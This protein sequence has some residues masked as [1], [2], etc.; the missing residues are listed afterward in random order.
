ME[1]GLDDFHPFFGSFV[2]GYVMSSNQIQFR[3]DYFEFFCV[4]LILKH[5]LKMNHHVEYFDNF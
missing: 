2:D 4:A 3:F 5:W 1:C